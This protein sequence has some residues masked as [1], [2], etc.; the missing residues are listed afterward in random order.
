M[1]RTPQYIKRRSETRI[2]PIEQEKQK[3]PK[4]GN[5]QWGRRKGKEPNDTNNTPSHQKN[6][7]ETTGNQQRT[8]PNPK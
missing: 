6:R 4:T 7:R 3:T 8:Q 5:P 2:H 1:D